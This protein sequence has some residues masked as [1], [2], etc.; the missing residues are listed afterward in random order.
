MALALCL[1]IAMAVYFRVIENVSVGIT[2]PIL[3]TLGIFGVGAIQE[4]II[5]RG[6]IQT[7][8]TGIIKQPLVCSFCTAFLFLAIHYPTHW[9][10]GGF[11]LKTLALYYV[12]SLIILHFVCDFVYKRTNCLWGAIVLHFLY[13]VGQSMLVI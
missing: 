13:N 11:S 7:R 4:E 6:Y 10:A 12:I 1:I 8:L 9:V 3:S 2:Y 5:F